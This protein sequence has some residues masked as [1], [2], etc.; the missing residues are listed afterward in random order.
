VD[1]LIGSSF[2]RGYTRTTRLPKLV[3]GS[4]YGYM[5]TY[6]AT[7]GQV[8]RGRGDGGGGRPRLA[9]D[10][11]A[12]APT[13][14]QNTHAMVMVTTYVRYRQGQPL[15]VLYVTNPS[16]QSRSLW[17]FRVWYCTCGPVPAETTTSVPRPVNFSIKKTWLINKDEGTIYSC[18]FFLAE[19]IS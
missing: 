17:P 9:S 11:V 2:S 18:I 5:G 15:G 13:E 12:L 8:D 14:V 16:E 4:Y 1:T 3:D 19:L 10:Y 6:S 7:R